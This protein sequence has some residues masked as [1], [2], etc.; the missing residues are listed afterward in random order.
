MSVPDPL[1]GRRAALIG[2]L[3]A[4]LGGLSVT[5]TAQTR[6]L[7]FGS[8]ATERP[9]EELRKLEPFQKHLEASL[10]AQGQ[11]VRIEVR[12]FPTYE[13]GIGAIVN[14]ELDFARLGPASYVL[15]KQRTPSLILLAT[16]SHGGDREFP[17][18]I[19]V[20][21]YSPILKVSDLRGKRFAFGDPSSTSG[22]YLPQA[23]LV[24]AGITAGDLAAYEFLGRHDKVVFAVASGSFDAGGTNFNTY[25]KYAEEKNLRELVRYPSPTQAWVAR[26]KLDPAIVKALRTGLLTMKGEGLDFID[27]N[28]FLPAADSDYDAL[29]RVMRTAKGF[30]G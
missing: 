22:R 9:S 29:R 20:S 11:F 18:V 28:G 21:R 14:G 26:H 27:R 2:L 30:G 8:Y 7:R 24:K 15:A 4:S 13:E 25:S 23:E 17:A 12:I 6:I 10:M 5:A 3:A 16:E 19:V 1:H